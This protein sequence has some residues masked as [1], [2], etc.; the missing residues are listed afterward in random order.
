MLFVGSFGAET[1]LGSQSRESLPDWF[2]Q[3]GYEVVHASSRSGRVARLA[4]IVTTTIRRSAEYDL[5]HIDVFSGPAFVWAEVASSNLRAMG[6]PYVLTLHGGQLPEFAA[7]HPR[8]VG[9]LLRK[10]RAVTCPSDFLAEGMRR[11]SGGIRVIPNPLDLERFH[12][13]ERIAAQPR[14]IW[15][16]AFHK[17]YQP[18]VAVEVLGNLVATHPDGTLVMIGP[19]KGDGSLAEDQGRHRSTRTRRS[20]HDQGADPKLRGAS[21]A[22]GCRHF[23]EHDD[24]GQRPTKRGGSSGLRLVCG[25]HKCG[26]CSTC[27]QRPDQRSARGTLRRALRWPRP[28]RNSWSILRW[29]QSCPATGP[30][31]PKPTIGPKSS[32]CGKVS[33]ERSCSLLGRWVLPSRC[34]PG[35]PCG[36]RISWCRP[37]VSDG[38]GFDLVR[39]LLPWSRAFG[40]ERD[41][42]KKQWRAWTRGRLSEVLE[43]ALNQVPYYRETWD[44]EQSAAA[45]AGDLSGLPILDKEPL[46]QAP[47]RFVREDQSS[48]GGLKFHTS[49]STGTPIAIHWTVREYRAALALREARSVR[50]A[51]ASFRLPRATFSGRQVVPDPESEGPYHRYNLAERQVYFSPFHL[52]SDTAKQYVDALHQSQ[53]E[54]LT[55]YAVSYYLLAGFMLEQGLQP[56]PLRGLVTTSEKVTSQMREVMEAAYRC[57]VF[58]EYSAVEN[59]SFACECEEGSLHVS[60]DAG[61]IEIVRPDGT[62]CEAGEVGEVVV[63]GLARGLISP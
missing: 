40:R 30:R 42:D 31:V 46:R 13:Q 19:D 51:G 15:V 9:R 14:L 52:R 61:I 55:G 48:H 23:P 49:G 35:H 11:F 43:V 39:G 33:S 62:Y 41:F 27:S 24:G 38:A 45:K 8:R 16:R 28:Y 59:A 7:R 53:I 63:T 12:Y 56:P 22:P 1:A 36:F 29:P 54:W 18:W 34:T 47:G 50:W 25:E 32:R 20:S 4:D 10:A 17:I 57:R 37:M 26:W 44:G 5:A 6:K 21:R 3:S 58:E 2:Q 60:L